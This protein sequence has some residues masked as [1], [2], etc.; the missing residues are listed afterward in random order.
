MRNNNEEY[1]A[2]FLS[3]LSCLNVSTDFI[4]VLIRREYTKMY[5]IVKKKKHKLLLL[6]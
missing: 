1:F 2:Y 3:L 6:Q 4:F 5:N